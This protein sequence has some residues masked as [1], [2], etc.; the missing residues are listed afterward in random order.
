[1]KLE[2]KT[3][4]LAAG[5]SWAK[6]PTSVF[7]NKLVLAATKAGLKVGKCI[8]RQALPSAKMRSSEAD[9][10]AFVQK[11]GWVLTKSSHKDSK[12]FHNK[13]GNGEIWVQPSIAGD[14]WLIVAKTETSQ[15]R[16]SFEAQA[17]KIMKPIL[18]KF[19]SAFEPEPQGEE[20]YAAEGLFFAGSKLPSKETWAT[21]GKYFESLGF[22]SD[23][24]KYVRG[25]EVLSIKPNQGDPVLYYDVVH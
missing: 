6:W 22:K 5:E 11:L 15:S 2:A 3:R 23:G 10:I 21:L 18:K 20:A 9:V 19:P 24:K 7:L 25:K 14:V 17:L 16:D 1:M 13:E 4:L 8:Y 12:C